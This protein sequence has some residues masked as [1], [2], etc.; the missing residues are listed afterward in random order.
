MPP[1]YQDTLYKLALMAKRANDKKCN[2]CT[3]CSC[4]KK[5]ETEKKEYE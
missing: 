3:S 4:N 5:E 2:N 1:A